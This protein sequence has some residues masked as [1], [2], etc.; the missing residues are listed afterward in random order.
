M[1]ENAPFVRAVRAE[2]IPEGGLERAIEASEAECLAL[3]KL[4]GLAAIG[5]LHAKFVLRR[6]GRGIVRAQGQVHAEVTQTCVVSLE[7][8]DVVLD[9]AIDVRFAAPVEENSGRRAA[10]GGAADVAAVGLSEED[11]PDPILDGKIDLGA[12]AAEFMILGLDPYPRKR[13]ADFGP[14]HSEQERPNGLGDPR[15]D[16][17]K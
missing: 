17:P 4:N 10:P 7:P 15:S 12:L 1:A 14:P 16:A 2:S 5:R 11:P 6:A 3:A 8:L 9:E 13:G